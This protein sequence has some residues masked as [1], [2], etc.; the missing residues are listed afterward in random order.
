MHG[1]LHLGLD[2]TLMAG[3]DL[4][5]QGQLLLLR[6]HLLAARVGLHG[7]AVGFPSLSCPL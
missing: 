4:P 6:W 1:E 5:R 3:A 7:N 2:V